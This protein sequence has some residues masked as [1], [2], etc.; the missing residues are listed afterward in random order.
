MAKLC[1]Y[2]MPSVFMTAN[3]ATSDA[4]PTRHWLSRHPCRSLGGHAHRC[5][6]FTPDNGQTRWHPYMVYKELHLRKKRRIQH[7]QYPQIS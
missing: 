3:R 5:I 6:I 4:F 1:R 2:A 7:T